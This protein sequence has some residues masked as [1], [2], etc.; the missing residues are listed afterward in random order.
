MQNSA[1]RDLTALPL[2]TT[3]HPPTREPMLGFAWL[4]LRQ[5]QEALKNGRLEEA[6]RLLCQPAAHGHKRSWELLQQV[7]EGFVE[8]G[9]RHLGHENLAAAWNDLVAAEQMGVADSAACRLR[10]NLRRPGLAEA[11]T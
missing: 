2:I 1:L 3:Y 4:A 10:Q 6:Q 7:A 9:A 11:R 8:R 5:A